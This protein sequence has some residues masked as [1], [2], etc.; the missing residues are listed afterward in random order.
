MKRLLTIGLLF[1]LAFLTYPSAGKAVSAATPLKT[2][3]S[4]LPLKYFVERVGGRRVAVQVMVGPGRS[5]ATYE[6]TPKQMAALSRTQLYFRVGVPFETVWMK[7]VADLNPTMA[8]IDL[9]QGL[10]LRPLKH[11]HHDAKK[12][13]QEIEH[14]GHEQEQ[15]TIS[16]ETDPHL[17]TDPNLVKQMTEQIRITLT[18]ADPAGA[19][20]YQAG[21]E[22]FIHD[23]DDLDRTIRQKLAN[24]TER[25]FL[26]F[27]PSWGYFAA[28]YDLQQVAIEASG[29]EPGPR[30]LA[31]IIEQ[32]KNNNISVIFVQQQFSRTTA[33]T[34]ARAING[35]VVAIDPLA[36][37]YLA[38]MRRTANAFARSLEESL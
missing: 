12:G 34:I 7:R 1:S 29:K 35:Q 15:K 25:R 36:E 9:R 14:R 22:A 19:A 3:V 11:H 17:W 27:H 6:P 26:V 13:N 20:D 5:P 37:D 4:V 18:A 31:G 21:A 30:T 16:Q 23:L 33:T 10:K 8:I 28:A 24:V 32:A 38:N 2:F